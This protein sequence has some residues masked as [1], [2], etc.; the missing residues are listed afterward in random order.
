L[1]SEANIDW[2]GK[3]ASLECFEFEEII[4]IIMINRTEE[5]KK[6]RLSHSGRGILL[7]VSFHPRFFEFGRKGAGKEKPRGHW[8]Y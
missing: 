2:R 5:G 3:A 6:H 7:V 8:K 4:L 1:A